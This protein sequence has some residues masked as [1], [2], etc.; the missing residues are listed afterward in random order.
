MSAKRA[1]G[2]DDFGDYKAYVG[3]TIVERYTGTA[4]AP[5]VIGSDRLS[6]VDVARRTGMPAGRAA[7]IISRVATEMGAKSLADLYR[8]STPKEVA[9]PGFGGCSVLLLFRLF[10]SFGL[11]SSAWAERGWTTSTRTTTFDSFK[12][13]AANRPKKKAARRG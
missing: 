13:R 2:D 7:R 5:C 10:E 12:R 9:G 11:D 8:R 1:S 4:H 3:K 6:Y